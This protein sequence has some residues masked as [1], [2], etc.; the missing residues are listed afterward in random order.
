MGRIPPVSQYV[1]DT[2]KYVV[3]DAYLFATAATRAIFEFYVISMSV[4]SPFSMK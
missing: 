4:G 3:H 2:W 1:Q